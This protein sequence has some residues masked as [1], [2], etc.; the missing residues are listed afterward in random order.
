MRE[1]PPRSGVL[2]SQISANGPYST[3]RWVPSSIG[4]PSSPAEASNRST[5]PKLRKRAATMSS[6]H[7]RGGQLDGLRGGEVPGGA[8]TAPGGPRPQTSAGS[9]GG[10]RREGRHSAGRLVGARARRG[11]GHDRGARLAGADDDRGGGQDGA[12][13][14]TPGS[15][16]STSTFAVTTV[17]ASP[18]S[19]PT[20]RRTCSCGGSRPGSAS[21]SSAAGR[22]SRAGPGRPGRAGGRCRRGRRPGSS[23]PAPSFDR[24]IS[25]AGGSWVSLRG[26][27]GISLRSV[28]GADPQGDDDDPRGSPDGVGEALDGRGEARHVGRVDRDPEVEADRHD[29][30]GSPNIPRAAAAATSER[31]SRAGSFSSS[32]S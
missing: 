11:R 4:S 24:V 9:P 18:V 17:P 26:N 13:G 29:D 32:R 31:R 6:C 20:G 21:V 10:E 25:T 22:R 15:P 16:A 7:A 5:S 28:R 30:A 1:T 12:L 8:V 23:G 19:P 14:L 3:V 27:G 2:E